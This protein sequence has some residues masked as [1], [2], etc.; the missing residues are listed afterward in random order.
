M[1]G[2]IKISILMLLT[3][4]GGCDAAKSA[5]EKEVQE[6]SNTKTVDTELMKEGYL[7][8][9][10]KNQPNSDCPFVLIDEKSEIKYDPMNIKEEKFKSFVDKDQMVYFKILPLRRANRCPDISPVQLID[11]KKRE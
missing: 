8:G 11:I 9:M 10:I 6:T 3:I 7:S 5:S 4:A 1:N 2:L